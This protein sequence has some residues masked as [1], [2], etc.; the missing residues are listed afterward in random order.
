MIL[1]IF[2]FISW[3]FG[4]IKRVDV[5]KKFLVFGSL[6]GIYFI[7]DLEIMFGNYLLFI[8]DGDSVRY[9]RIRKLD[10]GGYYIITRVFFVSFLDLVEYYSEDVDGLCCKLIY[11]CRVEK[12]V[13]FGFFYNIKDAWE[14]FREFL[15]L[16]KR[17]GVG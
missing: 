10:N 3:F 4:K 15:R 9:Y 13:I 7:R 2:V 17:L 16:I 1:F 11:L 14:I 5:E 8:R 6:F 12:F